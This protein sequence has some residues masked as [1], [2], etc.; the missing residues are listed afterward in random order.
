[1]CSKALLQILLG[2]NQFEILLHSNHYTSHTTIAFYHHG[3]QKCKGHTS[4]QQV[5][6]GTQPSLLVQMSNKISNYFLN[7]VKE[8]RELTPFT[9]YCSLSSSLVH[10]ESH[11]IASPPNGFFC[12]LHFNNYVQK[13]FQGWGYITAPNFM[14]MT[15]HY[16]F[17]FTDRLLE[18]W[19]IDVYSVNK[20]GFAIWLQWTRQLSPANATVPVLR[21]ELPFEFANACWIYKLWF[22]LV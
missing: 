11:A 2:Q 6:V 12:H 1:M 18:T 17:L 7:K 21:T 3:Y 19:G 9:S 13:Y 16:V 15:I 20:P 8:K 14:K 22:S 4:T 5:T 10:T